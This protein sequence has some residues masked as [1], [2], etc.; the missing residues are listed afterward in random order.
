M[1]QFILDHVVNGRLISGGIQLDLGPTA[2]LAI[3]I[4]SWW[5]LKRAW[6]SFR[7]PKVLHYVHSPE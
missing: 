1:N 3:I 7:K 6:I 4:A 5:F 2:I